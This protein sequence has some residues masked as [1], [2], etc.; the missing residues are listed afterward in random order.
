MKTFSVCLVKGMVS[1]P[2]KV[3]CSHNI[4]HISSD[5][6]SMKKKKHST[7]SIL[8]SNIF[9]HISQNII[10]I[11]LDCI[12]LKYTH[13]FVSHNNCSKATPRGECE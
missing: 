7:A 12:M 2:L 5:Q 4:T 13:A 6:N 8:H 11:F 10:C 3:K 9:D 1:L